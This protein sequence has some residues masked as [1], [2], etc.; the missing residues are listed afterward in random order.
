MEFKYGI[1]D[2]WS[3]LLGYEEEGQQTRHGRKPIIR[4][5]GIIF[6]NANI[7]GR[8]IFQNKST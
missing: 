3:L 1:L 2:V 7:I 6:L 4:Q 5:K 8:P